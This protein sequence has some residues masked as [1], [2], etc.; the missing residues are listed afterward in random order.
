M[1]DQLEN[2][3]QQLPAL[4]AAPAFNYFPFFNQKQPV[5]VLILIG[6]IF[7]CTS[8]Y[9]EYALDDGI[10]IH[11]N[12]YVLK[13]LRGVKDIVTKDAYNSFY[14][15]MNAK[16]QL[17]GGRYRPLPIITYAIEQE[18]IGT[19]RTGKYMH[20]EDLN[21]NDVLDDDEVTY[22]KEDGTTATSYEYNA[23]KDENSDGV[24][25]PNECYNCWDSNQNFRNDPAEDLNQDGVFNEIDCQVNGAMLRHFDNIWLY[26]LASIL[27][28]LLFRNHI[29][30]NSPDMAFLAALIFLIHPIHSEVVANVKSR[31]EIF[32]LIFI[33]LCFL[34]S[35]RFIESKKIADGALACVMFLLALL[36]KEYAVMLYIL[37]PIGLYVFNNAKL[38]LKKIAAPTLIF[39][40]LAIMLCVINA[41]HIDL[42]VPQ[43]TI[44]VLA[45]GLYV[46]LIAFAFRSSFRD[47][48]ASSLL[49]GFFIFGLCYL[50]L[51]LNATNMSPGVPDTELL[52]NPYLLATGEEQFATKVFVLLKYFALSV[53]PYRLISDYSYSAIAYRHLTD[54]SF[55]ISLLL[56]LT[57]LVLTIKLIAKRHVL[58]FALAVYLLWLIMLGNFFYAIGATMH[59]SYLFH[60]SVGVAIIFSWLI[61]KGFDKMQS[62]SFSSKRM[63]LAG[64]SI[65]LIVLC[66]CK[67]WERNWDWKNDVTLFLKDVKTSPNSVLI[68][69]NAGARWID[70]ADTKE[71]TG[72]AIPGEDPAKFNDYNGQ[73]KITDEEM[74]AGGYATKHEAAL[75][76]GI[77]Y[78]ERAV[79]LHP[80]YV[81][82]F[83]NL[84]L[85]HFK[86]GE[87][88]K[89]IYYW[90]CA[91]DLY[92]NNPYLRNYYQVYYNML[93]NRGDNAF[94]AGNY[95]LAVTEFNRWA[96][97]KPLDA[98]AWYNLAG[99]YF[100]LKK[101]ASARKNLNKAL[102]INPNYK[103]A[104]E[105]LLLIPEK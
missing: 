36:S 65:L 24:P 63:A 92:P 39:L 101:Y 5:F 51:R 6:I 79:Q 42:P 21:H 34:Y 67:T 32:S 10:I 69:G 43:F 56:N 84:G 46:L 93:K 7:Y 30:K 27:I 20:V 96:I 77:G 97:V 89:A 52:N 71:I 41:S 55:I 13:G 91:E 82:G 37:V 61:I 64:T 9:N 73:L 11:Q 100:N 44:Y 74:T 68:L 47:K 26:V 23:F 95:T 104:K 103:E 85:A 50:S 40:A 81:N 105:M 66:G 28:Y 33:S 54:A 22:K 59:E 25:Q 102:A 90:K 17:Q 12:D 19:Y 8:L 94:K 3:P 35:F 75:K 31:D 1:E 76:R 98:E 14:K 78:L 49:T 72:V 48:D 83:L 60:S 87:D 57:L 62:I 4:E 16:D 86:L 18:L 45:T 15:R 38:N 58:G 80:R 88:N 53:L 70:L 29:F 99:A 2:T